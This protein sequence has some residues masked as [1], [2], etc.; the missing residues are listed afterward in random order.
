MVPNVARARLEASTAGEGAVRTGLPSW[1]GVAPPSHR[2]LIAA[3]VTA[4][5]IRVLFACALMLGTHT[6]LH[7]WAMLRDGESYLRVAAAVRGAMDVP[8]AFDWRVFPGYPLAIGA[9][10]SIGIPLSLSALLLTWGGAGVAAAAGGALFNRRDVAWALAVLLPGYL[11]YTSIAMSEG[12]LLGM[13]TVG[14]LM[15]TRGRVAIGGLLLGYAG[16]IRPVACF[17]VI[18]FGLWS[19]HRREIRNA[20]VCGVTA[21]VVVATGWLT[22]RGWSHGA[23]QSVALYNQAYGNRLLEWPFEALIA[24]P[25]QSPVAA[26]KVAYIYAHVLLVLV[27]CAFA[28]RRLLLELPRPHTQGSMGV[29]AGAW[30]LGNTMF[31]VCVGQYWGFHEFHR[32][33]VPALPALYVVLEPLMPRERVWWVA[34]SIASLAMAAF[35]IAC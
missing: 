33:I 7:G 16:L 14:L 31:A 2:E 6:S 25:L 35:G 21:L 1:W 30:L 34:A 12:L 26:W 32:F 17:A 29:L 27:A 20:L 15:A 19:L 10:G 11:M 3:G 13:T 23:A 5:A 28:V 4:V 9:V 22:W 24:T 18:A 8:N